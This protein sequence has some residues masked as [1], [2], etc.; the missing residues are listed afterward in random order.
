MRSL[1]HR[2]ALGPSPEEFM[3]MQLAKEE[4][5]K[6][7]KLA[8]ET[9]DVGPDPPADVGTGTAVASGNPTGPNE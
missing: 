8:D 1:L 4:Q 5:Q 3:A 7:E 2:V 9:V 6:Q